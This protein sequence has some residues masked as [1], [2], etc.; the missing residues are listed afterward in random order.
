VAAVLLYIK[1]E[2]FYSLFTSG[3]SWY[4]DWLP[5]W[6][7]EVSEFESKYGQEFS[8]LQVVQTCSGAHP[9]SYLVGIEGLFPGG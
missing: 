8:L 3:R 7:T 4:S 2:N 9:A 1:T 5:A 6:T